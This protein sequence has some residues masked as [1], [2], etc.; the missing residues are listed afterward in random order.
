M[1]EARGT[2]EHPLTAY[3]FIEHLDAPDPK[4]LLR[5]LFHDI[6]PSVKFVGRF[7]GSFFAFARVEVDTFRDLLELMAGDFWQRGVRCTWSTVVG[8]LP[9]VMMPKKSGTTYCA[10]LRITTAADADPFDV[11][12]QLGEAFESWADGDHFGIAVVTGQYDILMTI[13][14]DDADALL[15]AIRRRVLKVGGIASTETAFAD[16]TGNEMHRD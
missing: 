2:L 9:G 11:M 8:L 14:A 13:G 4:R 1:K 16:L 12:A 10:L 5:D 6:D 15:K 7:V 3:V